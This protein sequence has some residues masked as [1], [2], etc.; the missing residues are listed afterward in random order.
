MTGESVAQ[1]V[2]RLRLAR[3]GRALNGAPVTRAAGEAAYA[4]SQSFARA[5]RAATG[6]SASELRAAGAAG[7]FAAPDG[8]APLKIEIVSHDPLDVIAIRNV[9]SYAELNLA[10]RKLVG[11]VGGRERIRAI[12]G[13]PYSDPRFDPAD[14]CV[15]DCAFAVDAEWGDFSPARAVRISGGTS[16]RLCNKGSYE[17][18]PAGFDALAVAAIESRYELEDAPPVI[19]YHEAPDT[20]PE[21]ELRADLYLPVKAAAQLM[22]LPPLRQSEG[23]FFG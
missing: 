5:M 13:I 12:Y 9:G 11:L 20:K 4:S 15:C 16:L 19:R 14:K 18:I 7:V 3:G 8:E 21:A 6:L 1:T 22:L 23:R 2:R 17:G 10:Y